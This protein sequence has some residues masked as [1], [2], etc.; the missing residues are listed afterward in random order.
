MFMAHRKN[1]T[2]IPDWSQTSR[3]DPHDRSPS[4]QQHGHR[5][6]DQLSTDMHQLL[7]QRLDFPRAND[8][9]REILG[10][11]CHVVLHPIGGSGFIDKG[12]VQQSNGFRRTSIPKR[13]VPH[14]GFVQFAMK[15][16][17]GVGP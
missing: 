1:S 5:R 4:D 12:I 16:G 11:E 6:P 17:Q 2:E 15:K 13:D 8:H 9:L 7:L 10:V 3:G 14:D